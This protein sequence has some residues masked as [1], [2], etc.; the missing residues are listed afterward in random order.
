MMFPTMGLYAITQ[1]ENKCGEQVIAEV[2]AAIRGGAVVIQY[3]DKKPFDPLYLSTELLKLCRSH[4]VPL[5]INDDVELAAN[6]GAD[7]VHLGKDDGAI[8]QARK[9]LGSKA[10]I[11]VSCYNDVKYA[12]DAEK[13]GANYVAFGRFYPSSSKPL[14]APAKLKT[15]KQAKIN[16]S[17]PI[18]AIGGIL[19]ENGEILLSAGAD[20]LAVIGGVFKKDVEQS[21]HAYQSLFNERSRSLHESSFKTALLTTHCAITVKRWL[22]K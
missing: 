13:E 4:N 11:G 5:L 15:L 17:V 1:T 18:V 10:I 16:L 7:G 20:L 21:A 12:L 3:R 19:P 6:I 8:K 2:A 22:S 9:R 14:A